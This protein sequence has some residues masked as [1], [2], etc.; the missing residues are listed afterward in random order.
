[1]KSKK[2]VKEKRDE[3]V[4]TVTSQS[5]NFNDSESGYFSGAV[6]ALGWVLGENE[7]KL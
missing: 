3:L 5:G 6:M 7:L 2:D 4:R 1:M